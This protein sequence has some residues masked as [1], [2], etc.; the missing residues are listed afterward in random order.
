MTNSNVSTSLRRSPPNLV[1]AMLSPLDHAER[2]GAAL[3]DEVSAMRKL[4]PFSTFPRGQVW[5]PDVDVDPIA[6]RSAELRRIVSG[7]TDSRTARAGFVLML[8]AIP[9]SAKFDAGTYL[10]ALIACALAEPEGFPAVVIAASVQRLWRE[11][12]FTPSISEV[13]AILRDERSRLLAPAVSADALVERVN[14]LQRAAEEQRQ[15]RAE[16]DALREKA[17]AAG[18]RRWEDDEMMRGCWDEELP[19]LRRIYG[20]TMA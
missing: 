4:V 20:G 14:S 12:S 16:F 8:E 5:A 10:D 15:A 9:N 11:K 19:I 3:A 18:D 7:P 17:R 2:L 13:L 6:G 1:R